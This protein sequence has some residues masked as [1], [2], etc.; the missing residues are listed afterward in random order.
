MPTVKI[1][2]AYD[3][4]KNLINIDQVIKSTKAKYTCPNCQGELIARKGKIKIHHFAHKSDSNC[5]FESYLHKISKT[6]FYLHYKNLVDSNGTLLYEYWLRRKCSGCRESTQID[7]ACSLPAI[8][9]TVDL[10]KYFPKVY[11]EKSFQEYKPDILLVSED[12]EKALFIEIAVTHNCDQKKIDSKI[13]I[14]EFQL[15]QEADIVDILRPKIEIGMKNCRRYNFKSTQIL[16]KYFSPRQ[17]KQEFNFNFL[18]AS[19]ESRWG[20]C[21]MKTI[22]RII[23]RSKDCFYEILEPF[24]YQKHEE[25]FY[26]DYQYKYYKYTA[27]MFDLHQFKELNIRNCYLCRFQTEYHHFYRGR[28]A[29]QQIP[30]C[31]KFKK[32]IESENQA[33]TCKSFWK[34]QKGKPRNNENLHLDGCLFRNF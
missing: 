3:S 26:N 33:E 1:Q 17:C 12:G 24:D 2:F 21:S 28:N 7:I 6:L 34:L 5:S 20:L 16:R 25:E 18:N 8:K 27:F 31:K 23:N 11:L 29:P 14:I 10:V 13:P 15:E 4:K 30:Y 19:G 32:T 9:Q 22:Q